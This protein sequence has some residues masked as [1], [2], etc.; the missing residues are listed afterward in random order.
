MEA[1]T[2]RATRQVR[3]VAVMAALLCAFAAVGPM[4]AREAGH[5]HSRMH[6]VKVVNPASADQHGS[7]TR[8]DQPV[9]AALPVQHVYASVLSVG[10]RESA[11]ST[12]HSQV[13]APANRGPP[14]LTS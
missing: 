13:R 4:V 7:T 5:S 9:V 2:S 10:T 12:D 6:L 11:H 14:S 8:F 1:M 3:V